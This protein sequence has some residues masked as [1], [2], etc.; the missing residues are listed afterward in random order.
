MP[1]RATT[2]R[3]DDALWSL[4]ERESKA[5]GVSAAQFVRDAALLRVAAVA[6]QRGDEDLSRRVEDVAAGSLRGGA[7][8]ATPPPAQPPPAVGDPERL[9]ALAESGLL[10]VRDD[11][12]FDR[13]TRLAARVLGAPVAL[14]SLV[15]ADRQVF[16]SCVGLEAPWE[17]ET[18]LSHS[19]CQHAVESRR[20]LVI[21]DARRHPVLRNN[22]AVRD[23]KVI[24]YAGIPLI[25]QEGFVLGTLCVIDTKPRDWTMGE[26]E[27]LSDLASSVMTEI[28]L[29]RRSAGAA[30][31]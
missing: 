21:E 30:A 11:P 29:R 14:V 4:L 13:L 31:S 8:G 10:D 2:V 26:L 25:D 5:Q 1:M 20:P 12:A 23:L 24:A 18:P 6:V 16:A 7:A 3:F 22:L 17:R 19:F 9:A 15:D 27:T 28:E